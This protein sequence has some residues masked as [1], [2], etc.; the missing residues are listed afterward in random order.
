VNRLS[1]LALLTAL[2]ASPLAAQTSNTRSARAA[3]PLPLK[4]APRPTSAAISAADLMTR[5]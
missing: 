5:L 1:T 3:R 4:H 2:V